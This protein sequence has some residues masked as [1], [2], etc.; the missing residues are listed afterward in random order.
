MESSGKVQL[1]AA[2]R[3]ISGQSLNSSVHFAN[4]TRLFMARLL[5]WQSTVSRPR[6]G[7]ARSTWSSFHELPAACPGAVVADVGGTRISSCI[8]YCCTSCDSASACRDM[9]PQHV[10]DHAGIKCNS[11]FTLFIDFRVFL[12]PSG[13]F[14]RCPFLEL[15]DAKVFL[16]VC[17][18][19][20]NNFFCLREDKHI[21]CL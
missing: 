21:K 17:G 3:F 10:E 19:Q 15:F 2:S 18:F 4:D 13:L 1:G 9:Y 8:R 16:S 14:W 12:V 7:Q 20:T 6:A 5:S 11:Q